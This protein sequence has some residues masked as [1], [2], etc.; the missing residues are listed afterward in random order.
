[1]TPR[2][3]PARPAPRSV[4]FYFSYRSPF[5]WLATLRLRPLLG[6]LPVEIDYCPVWEPEPWLT[7]VLAESGMTWSAPP[8]TRAKRAYIFEDVRRH[9]RSYDVPLVWP[10]DRAPEWS[11]PHLGLLFALEHGRGGA[12]HEAVFA[13]RFERGENVTDRAVLARIA[14]EVGLDA[15]ALLR[16]IDERDALGTALECYRRADADGVFGWPFFVYGRQKFWGNDRLDWLAE[17][18]AADHA[19]VAVAQ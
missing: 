4:R 11:L 18:V 6:G 17:T 7:S 12:Y 10:I 8:L 16:A 13:H 9:A 14:T 19:K 2:R 1:M 3:A 15:T 5:A